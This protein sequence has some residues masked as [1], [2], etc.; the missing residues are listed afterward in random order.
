M[1]IILFKNS[2]FYWFIFTLIQLFLKLSFLLFFLRLFFIKDAFCMFF[3]RYSLYT[4]ILGQLF[5]D[6]ILKTDTYYNILSCSFRFTKHS[7]LFYHLS[8][9]YL[10]SNRLIHPWPLLTR[11]QLSQLH[12]LCGPETFLRIIAFSYLLLG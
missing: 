12:L 6:W 7:N 1:L 8:L 11:L 2:N 5:L 4:W 3:L 10:P 9:A